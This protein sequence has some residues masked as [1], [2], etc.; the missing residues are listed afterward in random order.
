MYVYILANN[1]NIF[2][3]SYFSEIAHGDDVRAA[4][5]RVGRVKERGRGRGVDR[6][7]AV[8]R[9]RPI[10]RGQAIN[11]ERGRARG[12]NRPRMQRPAQAQQARVWTETHNFDPDI[13]AFEGDP[14]C[15]IDTTGFE[16]VDFFMLYIGDLIQH[17][18]IQTNKYAN[19]YITAVAGVNLKP[20]SRV[21]KWEPTNN[22]EMKTFIGLLL[23]MGI[24]KKPDINSYWSR[25]P[26]LRTTAFPSVMS[27]DRFLLILKFWHMSDSSLQ[28]QAND[29]HR[30]RLYKLR[31]VLDHLQDKFQ[32][33]FTPGRDI[34]IDESLL[35]WKGRLVFKQYIPLKRARF[36]IKTFMLCDSTGYTYRFRVYAGKDEST[37]A[38]DRLIPD[39]AVSFGRTGKEVVHLMLPLLD[40]GYR[41]FV[42]NWYTSVDLFHFLAQRNTSSCGTLRANRAPPCLRNLNLQKGQVQSV[43]SVNILAQK[44]KDKRDVYMLTTC[45]KPA[46][47]GRDQLRNKP[48]AILEYNQKMGAVDKHDQQLQP[49]DATRKCLKWYKKLCIRFMQ[50]ALLNAHI[51]YT[52]TGGTDSFLD[53]QKDVLSSLA[54]GNAERD[55]EEVD[56][57]A[58][59]LCGRHFIDILPPTEKA[60]PQKRCRVCAK[61]L[62][63]RKDTRYYCPDCPSKPGLCLQNC[64]R[65]YH[66]KR[67]YWR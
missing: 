60:R 40:K 5:D 10:N 61:K 45:H 27:R 44:F 41:L 12:Q 4:G 64:F 43:S 47:E 28:P 54:F 19:D 51:V 1:P 66:T 11:R 56:D 63:V 15:N 49:Y 9:G 6:G 50:I 34:A 38:I 29:P 32:E 14:G 67:F 42:D 55:G 7:R 52:T 53:F 16:P 46:V 24:V 8:N 21:R 35:L 25:D 33:V 26:L 57:H 13:P 18:T 23:L 65:D 31:D 20:H 62:R 17:F 59:R 30:D 48:P 37:A 39:D 3:I 58:V 2:S 22:E 36:G